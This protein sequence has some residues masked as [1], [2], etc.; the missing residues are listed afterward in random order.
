MRFSP[1]LLL[2]FAVI[3]FPLLGDEK[4][5]QSDEEGFVS[6]F[7]GETLNGWQGSTNGYFPED[8]VLVCKKDGGGNLY[9]EKEYADFVF[10]FEFK[11]TPG[12]NNGIG[13]RTPLTGNPAFDGIEIQVLDN[14]AERYKDIK[15]YQAHGS[16]YGVVP[17]KRGYLKPVGEWNS[18]EIAVRGS[19]FKVTLNDTVI[20]DADVK[21]ASEN[22]TL[23]GAAHPG[24]ERTQG[25]IAF[26]G[27]GAH[28]EFRNMRVKV[29]PAEE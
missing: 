2:V 19:H 8:G 29:L 18:E 26:C 3:S 15:P 24:L 25:H 22:G 21:Q 11:L 17:A 7:D 23:D 28:V 12:A 1:L 9:T 5:Q 10:R 20:V 4:P 16:V 27:H 6:L 13:I 14:D